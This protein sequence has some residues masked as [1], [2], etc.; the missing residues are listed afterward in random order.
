M[1]RLDIAEQRHF[2]A[3]LRGEFVLGP[4][5]YYIRLHTVL[6]QFLHRMLGR[7]GLEFLGRAQIRNQGKMYGNAVFLRQFPLQLTHSLHERLGLHIPDSTANFGDDDIVI[8][9]LGQ[10]HHTALYFVRDMGNY[11]H[12][13]A[14]V[15]PLPF[16]ADYRV[17]DFSCGDIVGLGG[18]NTEEALI[19]P[20]VEVSLSPVFS[21]IAFAVFIG[22][23]SARVYIYVRV[24][25]LDGNFQ[26]ASLEKFG[27]RCR[28][29]SFSERRCHS[30]CYEYVLCVHISSLVC[31]C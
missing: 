3:Q 13:L 6:L 14:Q 17:V 25:F 18:V 7:L 5:D 1:A 9:G 22:V 28:Y 23:Q 4:A 16:L 29:D 31:H 30:T 24:E 15:C 27:K 2:L 26:A 8:P 12:G 19:M 11:L 10:E 20:E 21:H